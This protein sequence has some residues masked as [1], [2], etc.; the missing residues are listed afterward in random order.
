MK[1]RWL[2]IT[3]KRK[4]S[5]EKN[6]IAA[7]RHFENERNIGDITASRQPCAWYFRLK[8]EEVVYRTQ[9]PATDREEF[10]KDTNK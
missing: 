7:H 8:A 4:D 9:K 3:L 1:S 6:R 2:Q 5:G 10:K